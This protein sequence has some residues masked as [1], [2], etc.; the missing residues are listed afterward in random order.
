MSTMKARYGVEGILYLIVL[1]LGMTLTIGFSAFSFISAR[2]ARNTSDATII[3]SERVCAAL[4]F[5]RSD[6][7][8]HVR[9]PLKQFLLDAAHAREVTSLNE[10]GIKA[11]TDAETA[12]KYRIL[13]DQVTSLPQIAC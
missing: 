7:N 3:L 12:T 4:N 8:L 6:S 11:H 5:G 1:A 10:T 9:L 2:D 13:A